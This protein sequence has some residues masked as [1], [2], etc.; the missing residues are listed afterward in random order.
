MRVEIGAIVTTTRRVR[1]ILTARIVIALIGVLFAGTAIAERWY[2]LW[3]GTFGALGA[4]ELDSIAHAPE[5]PS[6]I[7][8]WVYVHRGVQT[9]DCSP[10]TNCI[11][12]SQLTH[13]YADCGRMVAAEIRR[14]PMN[15]RGKVLATIDSPIPIWFS[16]V[17]AVVERDS[18]GE[19]RREIQPRDLELLSFCM[20]YNAGKVI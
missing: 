13:Y 17:R 4:V 7:A 12:T 2:I 9:F 1:Q 15:L 19:I 3:S 6:A 14:I 8:V 5:Y 11:A 16:I 20:N 10:P 18:D